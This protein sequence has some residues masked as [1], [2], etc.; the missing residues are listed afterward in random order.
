MLP[1][2]PRP[3]E[4]V[5]GRVIGGRYTLLEVLGEGGMGTVYRAEQSRP[6][7]RQ[8]ALKLI[9]V[10]MDSRTVLARFDAE[11]QALAMMDHPH[12]ARVFDGG[13]TRRPSI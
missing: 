5:P 3:S 6:V 11:R 13:A 2:A 4:F 10:G 12:I 8:V 9:K 7:R 1:P